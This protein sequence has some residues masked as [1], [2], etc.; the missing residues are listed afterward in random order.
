MP[1]LTVL[2]TQTTAEIQEG[3]T[4][5][6]ASKTHDIGI[7]YSCDG[8]P[9]CAMCRVKIHAGEE[10]LSPIEQKETDLIGNTY[11]ITKERLSCQAI[12]VG[13]GEITIDIQ[14]HLQTKPKNTLKENQSKHKK[15]QHRKN[16]RFSNRKS[17]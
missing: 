14:E 7:K 17:S 5:L 9:S 12:V 10:F 8:A 1:K 13:D 4:L 3:Q 6:Q 15:P 16:K 11:F 2:P